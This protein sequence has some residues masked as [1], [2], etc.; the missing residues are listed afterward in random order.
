VLLFMPGAWGS[1]NAA[2]TPAMGRMR[3]GHLS[4]RTWRCAKKRP[5]SGIILCARCSKAF[6][7]WWAPAASGATCPTICRRWIRARCFEAMAEDLR[8][9]LREFAGR[10]A[11][12]TAMILDSRTLQSNAGVGR[13]GGPRCAGFGRATA[14]TVRQGCLAGKTRHQARNPPFVSSRVGSSHLGQAH[15]RLSEKLW[16]LEAI[17]ARLGRYFSRTQFRRT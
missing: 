8:M 5:S 11:Q 1:A 6:A 12:P 4:R 2:L 9:L 15:T 7:M 10:K 17:Q 13:T 14:M 3:N 16:P